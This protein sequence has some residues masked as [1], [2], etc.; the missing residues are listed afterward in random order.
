MALEWAA[1]QVAAQDGPPCGFSRF[2]ARFKH[3]SSASGAEAA[4]ELVS[5][6]EDLE[7]KAWEYAK[8]RWK[9]LFGAESWGKFK[10]DY[11]ASCA[12]HV[13]YVDDEYAIE[14]L[15]VKMAA[16]GDLH[17]LQ[18]ELRE[19]RSQDQRHTLSTFCLLYTS[20]SPRD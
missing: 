10:D 8:A 17:Q 5:P 3:V 6:T 15:G 12:R 14:D 16:L 4:L 9:E 11:G 1:E 18:K 20:P 19:R 7:K 13:Q 2:L